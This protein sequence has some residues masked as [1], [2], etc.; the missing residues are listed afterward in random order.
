VVP[1]AELTADVLVY[2][3]RDLTEE[4]G[5]LLAMADAARKLARPD[6]A[7]RVARA[8]LA[9]AAGESAQ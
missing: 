2:L 7:D 8:T 4:R 3:V 5:R 6:A 1:D 9:L